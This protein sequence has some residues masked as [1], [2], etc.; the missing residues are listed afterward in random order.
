LYFYLKK[1]QI[2]TRQSNKSTSGVAT[3]STVTKKVDSIIKELQDNCYAELMM[4]IRG[5]ASALDVSASSIMN[6]VAVRAMSQRLPETEESMLQI[7]HVTKAN[8][9]KYG[10]ALLN[11]TQKYAKEKTGMITYNL[12]I[13]SVK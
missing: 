4:I 10:K 5:I 2:P 1:V 12:H 3:V 11:I 6:M 13:I 8:F 9:V 7:P